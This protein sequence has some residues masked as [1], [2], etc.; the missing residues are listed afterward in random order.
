MRSS[1]HTL[2]SGFA[3]LYLCFTPQP[4]WEMWMVPLFSPENWGG[5]EQLLKPTG[6][7]RLLT[8]LTEACPKAA[9]GTRTPSLRSRPSG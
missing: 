4:A 9:A 6:V 3:A 5:W 7:E 2:S 1:Q 8:V